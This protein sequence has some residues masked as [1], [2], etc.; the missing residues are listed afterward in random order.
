M[1]EPFSI[2]VKFDLLKVGH[3]QHPECAALRG[4]GRRAI[5]FP[6]LVGLIE[7]PQRGLMLYD[8][9]YSR[10]F[11]EATRRFPECLYR[12]ITPVTLPPEEELL[13]QLES[14][15]IRA[16]DIGTI[17]IS[18]FHADHVA[19]LRDFPQARFI[20]TR[21]ERA[22]CEK[23]GRVGRLLRAY[24]REL[25]PEVLDQRLKY[26]ETMPQVTLPAVWRPFEAAH[27]LLGDGSMLGVDLPGHAASQL[28]VAFHAEEPVFL[29][30]DACWKIEGLIRDKTPSRLAYA[31]FD[32]GAAYDATFAKLRALHLSP[33]A[34]LIIPS[35]CL[36]TWRERGGSRRIQRDH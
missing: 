20:A 27:D 28:G 5:D 13:A 33:G 2:H 22:L 8:T 24:L 7:H 35:H 14:R 32:N 23:K 31:L 10:H 17:F 34:P 3:C 30:G 29:I 21:A 4:G 18:H 11:N 12:M 26:A 25:M 19:G 15:G 16:S 6:A 9:G 36:T 1:R